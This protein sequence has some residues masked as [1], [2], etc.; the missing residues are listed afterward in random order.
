MKVKNGKK[1]VLNKI[2]KTNLKELLKALEYYYSRKYSQGE[3]GANENNKFITI[4]K[5]IYTIN[6]Y[7]I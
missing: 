4:I 6:E 5:W 3:N 2:S 1:K 7:K